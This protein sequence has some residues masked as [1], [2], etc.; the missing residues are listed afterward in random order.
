[1]DVDLKDDIETLPSFITPRGN[2]LA[3]ELGGPFGFY[4]VKYTDGGELPQVLKGSY[5]SPSKAIT[6][7]K[8]YIKTIKPL[9]ANPEDIKEPPVLKL[10]PK[11]YQ[12]KKTV[13]DGKNLSI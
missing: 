6:D 9:R 2:T 13:A 4:T 10:K 1:M 5:T 3:I 8:N 11:Q 7:I 12:R